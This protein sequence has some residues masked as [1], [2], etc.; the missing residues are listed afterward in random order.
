MAI[1]RPSLMALVS[2][3]AAAAVWASCD[4]AAPVV[5]GAGRCLAVVTTDILGDIVDNVVGDQAEVE[6]LLDTGTDPHQFAPSAAQAAQ[7]EEADIVIANGLGLEEALSSVLQ[8]AEQDGVEILEVA[9]ELD[10]LALSGDDDDSGL[11]PHFWMDPLRVAE[12]AG[13]VGVSI[14]RA[15]DLDA[16]LLARQA[17]SYRQQVLAVDAEVEAVLGA[18]PAQRRSLVTNHDTLGYFADRYGFEVIGVVIPGGSTLAEPSAAELSDLAEAIK[19]TGMPVV[20]AEANES[21]ELAEALA[22]ETDGDVEVV[23]LHTESL[24]QAGSG[25]E[26]YLDLIQT[27]AGQIANA[28]R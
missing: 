1:V 9:P 3:L 19:R 6:V 15:C 11:D 26:T 22:A 20:F 21:A 4:G 12:A 5:D 14:A 13:I 27:N 2:T 8:A 24:G 10:P 28:L 18:V 16:E 17:G 25:A 7:V 23:T